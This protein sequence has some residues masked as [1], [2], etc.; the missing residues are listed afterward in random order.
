MTKPLNKPSNISLFNKWRKW[1]SSLTRPMSSVP[2]AGFETLP[3]CTSNLWTFHFA[4]SSPQM[5]FLF[6]CLPVSLWHTQECKEGPWKWSHVHKGSNAPNSLSLLSVFPYWWSADLPL[7]VS[8]RSHLMT[9]FF[10]L[11]TTDM[12]LAVARFYGTQ[13][14]RKLKSGEGET[15]LTT[16]GGNLLPNWLIIY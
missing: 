14:A 5:P 3:F 15:A 9:F 11:H 6:P 10:L 2:K 1:N 13:T 16:G 4:V 8:R 7:V 12:G